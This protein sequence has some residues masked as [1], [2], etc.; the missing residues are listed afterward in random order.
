MILLTNQI[1]YEQKLEI[2]EKYDKLK[3]EVIE[4]VPWLRQ[5]SEYFFF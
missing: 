4:K 5:M 3:V 2:Y 1:V